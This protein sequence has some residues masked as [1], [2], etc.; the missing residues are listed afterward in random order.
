MFNKLKKLR[1]MKGEEV[2]YRLREKYR[3]ETDRVRFHLTL[4]VNSDREFDTLLR[5]YGFSVKNYLQYGPALRFYVSTQN[6]DSVSDLVQEDCREWFERTVADA[7]YITE[8]RIN[9][10]GYPD[11]AL[12]TEI[13]WNRDPVT[14]YVWPKHYWADYDLVHSSQ[15][16]PKIILEVNRQQHLT[17]LAKAFFL[18]GEERYARV[19]VAHME[20]W[21]SQ[22]PQWS[23]V[24]WHS[25]LDIAIRAISWM[26]TI[27]LLLPSK[28]LDEQAARR[29]CKSLFSQL[30]HIYRYP[31]VYSSPNT[32]LIGEATALFMGGLLFSEL[33][34]AEKWRQFGSVVL[35]NEM[36]RQVSEDGVYGELSSYYHCYATD[37]YLH[38]MTLAKA[39]RFPLPDW[40]WNR[41]SQML[42]VV[43]HFT[44]PDGTIP[45]FGDDDGGRVVQLGRD[46]YT[47]FGDGLSSGAV[48][49]GRPDF[50][51]QAREFHEESLW[52]LGE[53]G[54]SVFNSLDTQ[55]PSELSRSYAKDGYF[56]HRS[57]WAADDSHMVF[58]CGGL[59][60]MSGGHGHADALSLTLFSGG[61]E[62][63]IDPG[64]SVYNCAPEW[65]EYFR[66]SRAHNTVVVDGASQSEVSD[67][68]S[69]KKKAN[70]RLLRHISK[71]EIEYVDGEHDGYSGLP[72]PVGHRRRVIYIRPN[73][74]IVLDEL[75]GRG[76]HTYE[77]FYH[78]AP[79]AELI[80]FGEE[81]RGEVDCRARIGE[82]ALQMFMY[83]S[84]PLQ[85][86]A[87]CGQTDPIQGWSSHRYGERRPSPVLRTTLHPSTPAAVM[88]FLVPGD[89][90]IRSRRFETGSRHAIAAAIRDGDFD[91]IAVMSPDGDEV[92]MMDCVMRG[93]FFWMRTENGALKQLVAVNVRLFS[94]AGE[95]VF[96]SREPN[97]YVVAHFWQDGIVIEHGEAEGKVYVRDLRDRQFQRN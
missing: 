38:A 84:G 57:G 19:A 31:S 88:S 79:G 3:R 86:E 66:S 96:E 80:V 90:T 70:A 60:M 32:H 89:K 30:D 12:G 63:L 67:T 23:G 20:S 11:I 81:Q 41:L 27:F 15:V 36:Q 48:L 52:L 50:K 26:W 76:E 87:M 78:F 56:I 24:N 73:Y 45:L 44:R 97:P 35:I 95:I 1:L 61:R 6:R 71:T 93:E 8:H 16:D 77:L 28:S 92:R 85:A 10:L 7:E 82:S 4:G 2:L 62:M 34:G 17:R 25:S 49:F 9:L 69:W 14:G 40:M 72:D 83:G 21:I 46:N 18:T 37:F 13:D 42:E 54:C 33:P 51:Y 58:D 55:A 53:D 29:I 65:R 94:Y 22:N 47:S 91:D 74:W 75:S 64:T 43:M 59:G 5:N 39:N 68:F